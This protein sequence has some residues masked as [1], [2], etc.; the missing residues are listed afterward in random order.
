MKTNIK[1]FEKMEEDLSD[2]IADIEN[3]SMRENLIF[4]GIPEGPSTHESNETRP[5]NC[6]LLVKELMKDVLD[7]DSAT[8][9]IDRAHRIG[10]PRARKPRP[11]VVKFHKYS[12]RETVRK[13]SLEE[14]TK[15]LLQNS[16]CGIGVQSP[17]QYREARKALSDHAK[18]EE[19]R[20]NK[21]RI[22]GNKLFINNRPLKKYINGKVIDCTIASEN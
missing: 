11:I 9:I 21:S 6:E 7:I 18:R 17:R 4:Y 8:M 22:I 10:G 14:N 16:N 19:D 2:K 1:A 13:K 3:R 12:D 15:R 20:G 5:E